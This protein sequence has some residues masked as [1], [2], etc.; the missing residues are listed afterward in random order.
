MNKVSEESEPGEEQ[1]GPAG[2]APIEGAPAS[3]QPDVTQAPPSPSEGLATESLVE[4]EPRPDGEAPPA[5]R[6]ALSLL[7]A[8]WGPWKRWVNYRQIRK[9]RRSDLQFWRQRDPKEN[10]ESRLPDGEHIAV[11]GVWVAEL[12]SPSTVSGLLDGI[13]R[14]GWEYGRTRD[15]DLAKWLSDIRNGRQA[16]WINLGLV[17]RSTSDHFMTERFADLP[18]GVRFA[19]PSLRSV[20][21][22]LT[23]LVVAFFLDDERASSLE[24]PLRHS[25]ETTISN[26]PRFRRYQVIPHVLWN[27]PARFGHRPW[28]PE[29]KRRESVRR[30]MTGI[31][32]DCAHWVASNL[33]GV[34]A[35]GIRSGLFPTAMLMLTEHRRPLTDETRHPRVFY[36]LGLHR[37]YESWESSEWP[38][39]R[40]ALPSECPEE[41]GSLIFAC[42]R[43]DAFPDSPGDPEPESNWTIA[44]R[45]D[46]LIQG[47]L[48]RWA[49]TFMLD[50]YHQLL[51]RRRDRS[52]ADT[53]TRPSQELH[54]LR[55]LIRR[56]VYDMRLAAS[57]IR[58]F[59]KD[60][61][62][63][64]HGVMEMQPAG[65]LSNSRKELLA[66]F[67]NLQRI[68]AKQ[69]ERESR[70][71][72]STLSVSA[73]VAQ[74]TSNIR[75]QRI[76][77]LLTVAS[78][79][80]ALAALTVALLVAGNRI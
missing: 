35:S 59:V 61:W 20:T 41:A 42:R 24:L 2:L 50:G 48:T 78:V 33:P 29:F 45:A 30:L 17:A 16:G 65:S 75:L 8:R 69:V 15:E 58:T 11:P 71:L 51:S 49:L 72:L 54:A 14:L 25:F 7:A 6:P 1:L 60:A 57:E 10:E 55:V 13:A 67:R 38:G 22:S 3:S 74:A 53:S 47:I 18:Q 37:E 68:R 9:F 21:P 46:D 32:R 52:A 62:A 12:Y 64:K 27:R 79:I 70:L 40:M 56:D 36:G 76:L 43:R 44:Q 39:G 23:A 34:F 73:D 26:D 80:I 77:V 63:Y 28:T 4:P 66:L 31:E 5:R 19:V